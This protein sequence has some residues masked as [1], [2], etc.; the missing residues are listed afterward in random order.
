MVVASGAA[1]HRR[2]DHQGFDG[3]R[4]IPSSVDDDDL[5]DRDRPVCVTS[6]LSFL[7]IAL[8]NNL[9]ARGYSVRIVVENPGN[10]ITDFRYEAFFFFFFSFVESFESKFETTKKQI[11]F[12]DL[13]EFYFLT[14]RTAKFSFLLLLFFFSDFFVLFGKN[15]FLLNGVVH[16]LEHVVA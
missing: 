8:V 14:E 1:A 12:D 9:L 7:G 16:F 15:H 4:L 13:F 5:C 10:L 3:S 6:G 11:E 2:K